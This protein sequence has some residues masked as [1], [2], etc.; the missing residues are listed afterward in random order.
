MNI[1]EWCG[2][3]G[4]CLVQGGKQ[5]VGGGEFDLDSGGVVV[6]SFKLVSVGDVV[7]GVGLQQLQF[8]LLGVVEENVQVF[9]VGV[10]GVVVD[11]GVIEI[12]E[13]QV[14]FGE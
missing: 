11:F 7:I 2:V 13:E 6:L 3:G 4:V 12:I 9:V 5:F 10:N 14:G 8:D 1:C